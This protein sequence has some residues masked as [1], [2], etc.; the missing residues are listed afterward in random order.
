[1]E[2]KIKKEIEK[3]KVLKDQLR[4]V[5][6]DYVEKSNK[7]DTKLRLSEEKILDLRMKLLKDKEVPKELEYQFGI[8]WIS[9][10]IDEVPEECEELGI[11][12]LE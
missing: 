9:P 11:D 7:I 10:D 8:R 12:F 1:M 2:N 4:K 3:I 6:F 5:H